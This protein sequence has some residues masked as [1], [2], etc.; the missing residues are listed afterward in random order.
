MNYHIFPGWGWIV[1]A[2]GLYLFYAANKSNR[3]RREQ[4]RERLKERQEQLMQMLKKKNNKET[5]HGVNDK[6]DTKDE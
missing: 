3:N 5:N 1:V 2:I 4:K 6:M